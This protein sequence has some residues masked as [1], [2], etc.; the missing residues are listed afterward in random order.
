[1]S[2]GLIV[3]PSCAC[4]A[5]A[6]EANCPSCGEPLRREDGTVSRTRVAVLLGLTAAATLTTATLGSCSNPGPV[7]FYGP[8][9]TSGTTGA[10]GT[11]SSTSKSSA[12]TNSATSSSTG[13]V[14]FY[15]PAQTTSSTSSTGSGG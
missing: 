11:S 14:V 1:M 12:T 9:Q 4:H 13:P 8:A 2:L 3:C 7:V 5:K 15:G 6:S 10:G